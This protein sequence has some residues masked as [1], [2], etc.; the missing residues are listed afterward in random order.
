M[1]QL[2]SAKRMIGALG[3]ASQ[4]HVQAGP[5]PRPAGVHDLP[6]LHH[7]E[8][9]IGGPAQPRAEAPL[10]PKI[11]TKI[12]RWDIPPLFM[13]SA[14]GLHVTHASVDG[15]WVVQWGAHFAP[16]SPDPDDA[17]GDHRICSIKR[18]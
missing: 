8:L 16:S 9:H 3:R 17:A 14:K 4:A 2:Y 1:F 11:S 12:V 10:S 13:L 7:P 6:L 15:D 18:W 5:A